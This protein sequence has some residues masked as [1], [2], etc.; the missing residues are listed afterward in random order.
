[1]RFQV[2]GTPTTTL[3]VRVWPAGTAEPSAWTYTRTDATAANQVAGA[4]SL[5]SYAPSTG[6]NPVTV[7]YDDLAVKQLP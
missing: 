6:N 5:K 1:V 3:R 4:L 7:S 2:Q